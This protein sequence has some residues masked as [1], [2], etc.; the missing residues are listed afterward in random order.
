[1]SQKQNDKLL[2]ALRARPMTAMDMLGELGIA[3]G[4]ARVYDLRQAGFDIRSTEI[5]VKNRAGEP[6]RVALY[7]LHSPQTH[8]LPVHP[9]R[10]VMT[11]A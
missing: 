10:G 11:H 4:A 2:A 1:M 6:C 3:R 5:T 7:S 8:L 9:G